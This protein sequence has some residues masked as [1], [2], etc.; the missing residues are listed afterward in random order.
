[1]AKRILKLMLVIAGYCMA[2][3]AIVGFTVALVAYGNDYSYDF[4]THRIIQKGHIIITSAP[5]GVRVKVDGKQLNKKTPYQTAY[6]VGEHTFS[7]IKDGYYPWTKSISIVAGRVALANYVI[8][9]PKNIVSTTLDTRP[10]IL[11][12]SISKD[13]RHI[14]YI[15]GGIDAAV[16]TLD[17]GSRKQMK[18][19]VPKVASAEAP[20]EVLKDVS[21]S[22]DASH[23]LITT[24]V[25]GQVIQRLATAGS[26]AEPVN[27]TQEFG[28]DLSGLKFSGSNWKQL[29]WVSADGLRRLDVDAKTVSG[30]LA[31]KVTQFWPQPDHVLY[32]Q[33]TDL[34]RTLWSLD[35]RGRKQ[36]IVQVLAESASYAVAESKYNGDDQLV[37]VPAATQVATLYS[38]IFSDT[39]E[40]KVLAHN[41]TGVG[42]APDGHLLALTSPTATSVYDL[43][44][45]DIERSFVLY[46]VPFVGALANLTW[47]DSDHLLAN[48][49]GRLFLSE[50]DG[51]N[52]IDL[53]AVS[54][55]LPGYGSADGRAVIMYGPSEAGVKV[56]QLVIRP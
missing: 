7:L 40:S 9:I 2:V 53:G 16:V 49:D 11:G 43:E 18:L 28:F 22:D 36:E 55:A 4:S 24:D 35:S 54:G 23:L 37:V 39:P 34:G 8:L 51:A 52:S 12:Q 38:A 33:Q 21:W 13:H 19:Y 27:L 56:N 6:K 46:R 44:R 17:V 1:M 25:G 50:F 20:A 3:L 14:A 26:T 42:F 47:F 31:D 15:T 30:V 32:V 41:V 29:Y 48:R 5:S 10:Q 45:S